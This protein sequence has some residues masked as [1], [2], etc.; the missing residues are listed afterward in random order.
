MQ[1]LSLRGEVGVKRDTATD[2]TFD[3]ISA[4]LTLS[5]RDEVQT[6][7]GAAVVQLPSGMVLELADDTLVS[8]IGGNGVDAFLA[9][10]SVRITPGPGSEVHPVQ[11]VTPAGRVTVRTWDARIRVEDKTAYVMVYEGSANLWGKGAVVVRSG[12]T[13]QMV[14]GGVPGKPHALLEA[15]RWTGGDALFLHGDKPPYVVLRWQ[16]VTGAARYLIELTPADGH[17]P[18]HLFADGGKTSAESRDLPLG[19]F[20][21]RAYA[22]D[23]AFV[24]GVASEPRRIVVAGLVGLGPTGVVTVA[25][26]TSPRVTPP[27]GLAATVLCDGEAIGEAGLRAGTH[28]LQIT[29]AGLSTEI[30]AIVPAAREERS[31]NDTPAVA[32]APPAEDAPP[33]GEAPDQK[34]GAAARCPDPVAQ[35]QADPAGPADAPPEGPRRP[36]RP[37]AGAPAGG[38]GPPDLGR[39]AFLTGGAAPAAGGSRV[40]SP[41]DISRPPW[42]V[43]PSAPSR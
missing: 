16:A 12:Q 28:R 8:L 24:P 2:D 18:L 13:A 25:A 4:P 5:R 15:P 21:A 37:I 40:I 34:A 7:A 26:G 17:P 36:R 39:P 23:A 19:S 35:G 41:P 14:K 30:T 33:K 38:A 1:V 20:T 22:V 31:P 10:G 9:R 11:V 6:R 32:D 3:A 27:L 42:L 43:R 29:V